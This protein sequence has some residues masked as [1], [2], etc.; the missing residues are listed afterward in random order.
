MKLATQHPSD[1]PTA[2][3]TP[4][5]SKGA[6]NDWLELTL[7]MLIAFAGLLAFS[8]ILPDG[9]ARVVQEILGWC[10]AGSMLGLGL[11]AAIKGLNGLLD[12]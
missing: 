10:M 1:I 11:L 9:P 6:K 4:N 3:S 2:G 12:S 8:L 7:V 5:V